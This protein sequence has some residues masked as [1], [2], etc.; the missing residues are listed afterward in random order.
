MRVVLPV[1]LWPARATLRILSGVSTCIAA[2]SYGQGSESR[3]EPGPG[4]TYAESPAG[5]AGRPVWSPESKGCVR[6]A[7]QGRL[8]GS[9]TV[10]SSD[11]AKLG[12]Y[13]I[14]R[15]DRQGRDGRGLPGA[16]DPLIG[17]DGG[18]QDLP[19]RLAVPDEELRAVPR[20]LHARG[21]ERRHPLAPQHR[22]HPRR[23]GGERRGRHLHRHGVRARH[24]PAQGA[25]SRRG[26]PMDLSSSSTC[27]SQI[28]DGARLRALQGRRPPR[29]QAGQHSDHRPPSS[30]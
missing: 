29:R 13:E 11:S 28:A 3:H 22:H 17:R 1:S 14:R 21:A 2:P 27:S 25:C 9:A 20:P 30:G 19:R 10:M 23:G 15:G 6:T 16:S 12:R 7:P 26:E 24:Q 5:S 8:L 4:G 18:A